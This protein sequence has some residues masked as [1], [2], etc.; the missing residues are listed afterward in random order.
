MYRIPKAFLDRVTAGEIPITYYVIMTSKGNRIYSDKD[1]A[2]CFDQVYFTAGGSLRA[3]GLFTAGNGVSA[4]DKSARAL[5]QANV[6][7]TIQ[8]KTRDVINSLTNKQLSN[9]DLTLDNCD[10]HFS[11]IIPTEPFLTRLIWA[12]VGFESGNPAD[13]LRPF[14]GMIGQVEV[15]GDQMNLYAE[16]K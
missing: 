11:K 6:A 13:H 4:L 2:G 7:R 10:Y 3:D 16:E 9:L 15:T 8:P 1:L 12:Y 5:S 14:Q